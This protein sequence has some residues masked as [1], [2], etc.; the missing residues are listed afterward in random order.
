MKK[1]SLHFGK[2]LFAVLVAA[3]LAGCASSS[4]PENM[5][6]GVIQAGKTQ[7]YSVS[8]NS[9]G[10]RETSKMG[11]SQ[12]ADK[13]FVEAIKQS[14]TAN[15]TFDAVVEGDAGQYA[16]SVAIVKLQQPM[17]GLDMTVKMEAAWQLRKQDGKVVWEQVINSEHTATVSDAF[18]GVARLRM[19]NEGAAKANIKQALEKISALSL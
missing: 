13:D 6:A 17:I 14:I 10:G 7:P 16:L 9:S 12:I 19:A 18:A 5:V 4:K 2:I 15:K 3:H 8:V 1:A 11:A